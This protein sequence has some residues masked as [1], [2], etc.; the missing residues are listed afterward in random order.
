MLLPEVDADFNVTQAIFEA[1]EA[2]DLAIP[3]ASIV[4]IKASSEMLLVRSYFN[5]LSH[6]LKILNELIDG[7]D[8]IIGF[9]IGSMD[10]N[11]FMFPDTKIDEAWV[12]HCNSWFSLK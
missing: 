12:F 1:V 2:C 11:H 8:D 9:E 3:N 6:V 7:G 10:D 4:D 5:S